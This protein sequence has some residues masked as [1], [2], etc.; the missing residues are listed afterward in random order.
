MGYGDLSSFPTGCLGLAGNSGKRRG[1][2]ST[3]STEVDTYYRHLK[4][5]PNRLPSQS[6][7]QLSGGVPPIQGGGG[8]GKVYCRRCHGNPYA[9]WID[10]SSIGDPSPLL[11]SPTSS[12]LFFLIVFCCIVLLSSWISEVGGGRWEGWSPVTFTWRLLFFHFSL[13]FLSFIIVFML[14]YVLTKPLIFTD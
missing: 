8:G 9:A 5:F 12:S 6:E 3:G 2:L 1:E 4:K 13:S 10:A 7:G 11:T 14:L